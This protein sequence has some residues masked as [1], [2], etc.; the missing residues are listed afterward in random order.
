M[1][2]RRL[3]LP[4]QF[5]VVDLFAGPGGLAE[6]FSSVRS[7]GDRRS[8]P[9]LLSVEKERAAHQTLLLRTFLREFENGF[10]DRY[11]E[12]LN[13]EVDEPDWASEFPREWMNA[14]SHALQL[15]L[16]TPDAKQIIDKRLTAIKRDYGSNLVLIGVLACRSFQEHGCR[17]LC[18]QQ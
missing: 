12:F 2:K 13:G 1:R 17:G 8:F 15:E 4:Q 10:P 11:Y 5:G 7:G 14:S 9:I 6:G 18:R 3:R 16:G